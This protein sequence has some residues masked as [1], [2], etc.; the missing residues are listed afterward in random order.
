MQDPLVGAA[1]D[2]HESK[3]SFTSCIRIDMNYLCIGWDPY[4]GQLYRVGRIVHRGPPW[5][6]ADGSSPKVEFKSLMDLK[7][8][9]FI[10]KTSL[11]FLESIILT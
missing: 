9:K 11:S 7:V 2:S 5:E 8:P 6:A 3:E 1:L 4:P 10:P